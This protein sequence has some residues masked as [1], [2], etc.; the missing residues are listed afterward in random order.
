MTSTGRGYQYILSLNLYFDDINGEKGAEDANVTA[1]IY[2]KKDNKRM[3]VVLLPR[4]SY[5]QVNY[6]N[7]ECISA[8][9]KTRLIRYSASIT[10]EP[11]Q[12][13]DEAGYYV[14]WERCCRNNTITNIVSPQD[15]GMAFYMEFPPVVLNNTRLINNSPSFIIPKGDYACVNEPFVFDFG[16][17]DPDGDQ[18]VYKLVT[19]YNGN[20]SS[21]PALRNP[22]SSGTYFS[23]PYAEIKWATGF[24]LSN[25]IPGK[26]PLRVNPLTGQITF[27]ANRT[28]LF[29]FSV[30]AEEYRNGKKIGEVRRDFQLMVIDCPKNI[31]PKVKMREPG[32]NKFYTPGKVIRVAVNGDRC[33]NVAIADSNLKEQ[34]NLSLRPLN[35]TAGLAT[36]SPLQGTLSGP[37]DTLRAKVCFDECAYNT[38]GEPYLFQIIASDNGCPI[39]KRDTLQIAIDFER[40]PNIAPLTTTDLPG[41]T[42]VVIAGNSIR[43]Q[44]QGIDPDNEKISLTAVGRGFDLSSAG[45]SFTNGTAVGNVTSPFV[46]EPDCSKSEADKTYIIDFIVK[47]ERCTGEQKSDTVTVNLDYRSRKTTKPDITTTLPANRATLQTHQLIKFDVIATDSDNDPIVLRAVGRGFNLEEAGMSFRN[48]QRGIGKITEPFSWQPI[49]QNILSDQSIYIIDFIVTDNSCAGNRSDTIT[50]ELN[51]A[52]LMMTFDNFQPPNVFTPNEDGVNDTFFI[53]DLPVDNCRDSFESIEIFNRWGKQ[54]YKGGNREFSWN[55]AGY[56]TG[57][58]YYLIHYRSRTYKGVVSLL[59]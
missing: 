19:P 28:G 12:Y 45:M 3:Q 9:L 29:V 14:V 24:N 4:V 34:I 20:T 16:A 15:A 1:V 18:L 38:P 31:P 11:N 17:Q 52:D 41:N 27:T 46:W 23:A 59:R 43:F 2:S 49:C 32:S 54:V 48:N 53:P 35:F 25:V 57:V 42:A 51:I 5:G 36:L 7:P 56:P 33:F 13:T 47:D 10:L 22:Y 55:G 39:P 58:Y 21:V 40:K 26:A 37:A 30:L 6:T 50:V 8:R 44:V